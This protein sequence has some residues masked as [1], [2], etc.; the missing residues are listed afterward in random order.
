MCF[1]FVYLDHL[2]PTANAAV[3]ENAPNLFP[4]YPNTFGSSLNTFGVINYRSPTTN[5]IRDVSILIAGTHRKLAQGFS[6]F[7][8][9]NR[10]RKLSQFS[11]SNRSTK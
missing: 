11:I 6:F 3:I 1:T 9:F 2:M 10:I 7:S 4:N 8:L 5:E